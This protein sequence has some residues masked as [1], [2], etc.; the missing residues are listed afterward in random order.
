M[1]LADV[2][3]LFSELSK[4]GAE[5]IVAGGL[6][7]V[8]HGYGRF[9][10]DVDLVLRLTL[11]NL[12]KALGAMANLGYKPRIPVTVED[13]ADPAKRERWRREKGMV[14]LNLHSDQR[15]S[16]PVDVFVEEP[17]DFDAEISRVLKQEIAPGLIVNIVSLETLLKM[18]EAAGRDKDRVD[19]RYLRDMMD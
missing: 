17:F 13:L 9:T 3:Q 16:T 4:A 5:Y 6:A 1:K 18:K 11:G 12:K 8:A 15:P 19:L 14:V 7:V 10:E 2:E